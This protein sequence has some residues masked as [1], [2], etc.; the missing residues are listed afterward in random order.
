MSEN[1]I[2]QRTIIRNK[3]VEILETYTEG[4]SIYNTRLANIEPDKLPALMVYTLDEDAEK[5]QDEGGYVRKM[6]VVIVARAKG[7][8]DSRKTYVQKNL[9]EVLDNFSEMVERIFLNVRETLEKTCYLMNLISNKIIF[10]S[11]VNKLEDFFGDIEMVYQVEYHQEIT[12]LNSTQ[13]LDDNGKK[14]VFEY[15]KDGNIIKK[16]V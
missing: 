4:I 6:R 8:E 11:N 3:I 14:V 5:T 7:E 10:P 16:A 15:T 2:H 1:I 13:A 12:T 9:A